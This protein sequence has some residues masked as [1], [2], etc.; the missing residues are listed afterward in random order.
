MAKIKEQL[1]KE[2]YDCR[3]H[4]D[5]M[6]LK[7]KE[8]RIYDTSLNVVLAIA[9]SGSI[10]S[11]TIWDEYAIY[12]GGL[13]ALSQLITALK[14]IFPFH[15]H[16][17]TL[18]HRCYKQEILFLE[19]IEM[20]QNL[21]DKSENES[22]IKTRLSYLIKQINENEFFDDDDGFEFSKRMQDKAQSM[23]E[24]ILVTKYNIL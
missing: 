7:V 5:L 4:A 20:W 6:S 2:I 9:S 17:H 12:W 14:P 18:N 8:L 21:N 13:I 15:K 16:V 19:L 3:F 11:W 22:T 1:K 10:A 23:T 24:D